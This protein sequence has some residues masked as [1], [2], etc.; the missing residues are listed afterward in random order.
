VIFFSS[1]YYS[2]Y[3][4]KWRHT[5]FWLHLKINI[6]FT[7]W[8][9]VKLKLIYFTS[10]QNTQTMCKAINK[11]HV[12]LICIKTMNQCCKRNIWVFSFFYLQTG[13]C[14]LYLHRWSKD[15]VWRLCQQS[16]RLAFKNKL[17]YKTFWII[18]TGLAISRPKIKLVTRYQLLDQFV[19]IP[20]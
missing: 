2:N 11:T 3:S 5:L 10:F 1:H 16:K 9:L 15:H 6:F 7:L 4:V 20:R 17:I 19:V 14:K 18:Y 8:S 12:L 13:K